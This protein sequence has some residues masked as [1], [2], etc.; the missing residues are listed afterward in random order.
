MCHHYESDSEAYREAI[1][2]ELGLDEP[3]EEPDDAAAEA[4]IDDAEEPSVE[5]EP[6]LA[7]D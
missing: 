1:R 2:E 7:D 4:D 3:D 6:T 5:A